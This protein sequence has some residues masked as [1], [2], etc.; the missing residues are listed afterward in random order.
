ML[1]WYVVPSHLQGPQF[2]HGLGLLFELSLPRSPHVHVGFHP[3]ISFPFTSQKHAG[4]WVGY[5]KIY[6]PCELVAKKGT[7]DGLVF[8]PHPQPFPLPQNLKL[9]WEGV[10]FSHEKVTQ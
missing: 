6:P 8:L 7:F 9:D 2:K 4:R 10:S 5:A 3:L 1:P